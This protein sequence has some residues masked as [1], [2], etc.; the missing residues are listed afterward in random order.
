MAN[1][2]R[3]AHLRAAQVE[4]AVIQ[5]LLL[6]HR[7]RLVRHEWRVGRTAEHL[8]R[9]HAH[10]DLAR[11]ELRVGQP[12]TTRGDDAGGA[13]DPLRAHRPRHLVRGRAAEVDIEDE[14]RE[15]VAVAEVDE[16]ELAVVAVNVDPAGQFHLFA[17]VG[18]TKL[19]AGM[20][21]VTGL[22]GFGHGVRNAARSRGQRGGGSLLC[23]CVSRV[24]YGCETANQRTAAGRARD[25]RREAVG[26]TAPSYWRR[27]A[28]FLRSACASGAYI[29]KRGVSS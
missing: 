6:V 5:P 3:L 15:A 9:L 12:F 13:E 20:G 28:C 19:A 8:E 2:E 25:R 27:P 16:H 7:I 18:F 11:R 10:F 14:L 26:V 22:D 29:G 17:D 24:G 4:V 21:A 1:A 23:S